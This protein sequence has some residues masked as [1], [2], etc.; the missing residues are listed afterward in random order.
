MPFTSV[1]RATKLGVGFT[2]RQ[3]PIYEDGKVIFDNAVFQQG[4]LPHTCG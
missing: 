4:H 1:H 3:R 2:G